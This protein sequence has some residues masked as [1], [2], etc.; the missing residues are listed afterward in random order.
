MA[1]PGVK[2]KQKG[3]SL[4]KV[5]W[6]GRRMEGSNENGRGTGGVVKIG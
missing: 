4:Q 2:Y 5:R 1:R 3:E 6:K